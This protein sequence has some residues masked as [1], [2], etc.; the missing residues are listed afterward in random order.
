MLHHVK[1]TYGISFEEYVIKCY[2]NDIR[3]V[4]VKTG[5]PLTFK[6]HK[7][8]PWFSDTVK[9]CFT[10]KPHSAES[11]QKI[12]AGCEK[13]AME[14]F[15]VKNAFQ[16]ESI[17]QKIRETNLNKYGVEN[18][19]KNSDVKAKALN[20]Y[21]ETIKQ[22][23]E[24]GDY[25][26]E[27]NRSTL[28]LDF[29]SKLN[30]AEIDF[31]S[32]YILDGKKFDFYVPEIDIIIEID[33]EAFHKNTLEN[34]S[35]ITIS[36]AINDIEKN[37][38]AKLSGKALAR[39]RWNTETTFSN[40]QQ[41]STVITN[42]TYV[43]NYDI[44]LRQIICKKEYFKNYIHTH[45]K[46]KLSSY[47]YLFVKFLKTVHPKFP[48]IT[49]DL[50]VTD[51]AQLFKN[52]DWKSIV[53]DN[54]FK[55][56]KC[57]KSLNFFLKSIFKSYWK[58]SYKNRKSPVESWT[59]IDLLK[60]IIKYRIGCNNSDEI[61]DFSL[62]EILKGMSA[63]RLTISFF[64]PFLA[65][66][67]Y[68]RLLLDATT[69]TVLDPCCGFGGRLLGFKMAYPNGH[70]IGCEPNKETFAELTKLA[71]FFQFTNVTIHNIKYENFD[72]SKIT[73][74]LTF[75]SIPY[76]DMETYSE[77][78]TISFDAWKTQFVSTLYG[79]N[80]YINCS[81]PLANNLGWEK[82]LWGTIETTT[83]HY[84]KETPTKIEGI[85]RLT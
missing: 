27:Y 56:Q 6:A 72:R 65:H 37:K 62:Y 47:A 66:S 82:Y 84:N 29:E 22:K 41:L 11:R 32:P 44:Q 16:S 52:Y 70:Y 21:Y 2:Y 31:V 54:N 59:D 50:S 24:S 43:P 68:K 3:P 79:E 30:L 55:S 53:T 67:I 28:E 77:S 51:V 4:C 45:G 20:Q 15:G 80:V 19:A 33:G 1:K 26:K 81:I 34:L 83:S 38:I 25:N 78:E 39:I 35:L 49:T 76:F 36:S 14:L 73:P 46:D 57:P 63:R 71:E 64:N 60:E 42:Y 61:F 18:A 13:R 74:D 23:F 17:K 58:S 5:K 85:Y 40:I 9:N 48:E 12:K 75:T 8:G 10:R 7:L 69:P